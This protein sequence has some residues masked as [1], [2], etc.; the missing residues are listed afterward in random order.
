MDHQH[1][2]GQKSSS[3]RGVDKDDGKSF[4]HTACN[5]DSRG[6]GIYRCRAIPAGK[7]N[8]K[9][10][11]DTGL[12]VG[13]GSTSSIL[14]LWMSLCVL[15]EFFVLLHCVANGVDYIFPRTTRKARNFV[16]FVYF[17]EEN[18]KKQPFCAKQ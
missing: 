18:D 17:V 11:S 16:F 10:E 1:A 6:E 2:L 9:R 15:C 8:G 3:G 5:D 12:F 4:R 7:S 14:K 13:E